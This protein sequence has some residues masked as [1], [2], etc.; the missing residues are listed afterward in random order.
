MLLSI[1]LCSALKSVHSRA[2]PWHHE[3]VN[4]SDCFLLSG[5]KATTIRH[6]WESP[7]M[8]STIEGT[9][10]RPTLFLLSSYFGPTSPALLQLRQ[11]GTVTIASPPSLNLTLFLYVEQVDV[12]LY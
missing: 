11:I 8:V 6:G 7:G 12:C 9:R 5:R 4:D 3:L 10:K 1:P 2:F